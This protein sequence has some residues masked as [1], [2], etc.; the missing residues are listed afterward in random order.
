MAQSVKLL[1][2]N[3][4]G[5]SSSPV[6]GSA[7]GVEPLKREREREGKKP[8][9]KDF[10]MKSTILGLHFISKGKVGMVTIMND[11]VKSVIG[12]LCLQ[13]LMVL[14]SWSWYP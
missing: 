5:V 3:L 8:G 6:L 2:I 10:F 1:T 7:L 12:I 4:R 14:V 13:R 9:Y 11:R